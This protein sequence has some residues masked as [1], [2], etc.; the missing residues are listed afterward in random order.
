M[1]DSTVNSYECIGFGLVLDVFISP[2]RIKNDPTYGL[3]L[4]FHRDAE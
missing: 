3:L 2:V 1:I 4:F